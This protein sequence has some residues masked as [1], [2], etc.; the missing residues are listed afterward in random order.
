MNRICVYTVITGNYDTLRDI[1]KTENGIDYICYTNNKKIKSK[2]WNVKYISDDKL[3]DLELSRKI[4]MLGTEELK[5]YDVTIYIDGNFTIT[6][7]VKKFIKDYVDLEKYDLVGFK[8]SARDSINE[9]MLACLIYNKEIAENIFKLYN[10]YKKEK[11]PDNFGLIEAGILF[12]NFNNVTLNKCMKLWF[13]MYLKYSHR[14]Q[15]S[16]QYVAWV[17]GLK[18]NLLNISIWDNEYFESV[19]HVIVDKVDVDIFFKQGNNFLGDKILKK[20]FDVKDS[21]IIGSI[22]TDFDYDEAILKFNCNYDLVLYNDRYS[23]FEIT[24]KNNIITENKIL[25]T[26][27]P[28]VVL[29][30]YNAKIFDVRLNGYFSDKKTVYLDS[31]KRAV[32]KMNKDIQNAEFCYNE[33]ERKFKNTEIELQEK[34]SDLQKQYYELLLKYEKIVNSRRWKITNKLF[35]IKNIFKKK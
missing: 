21:K 32:H 27:N 24:Y 10:F 20:S 9:E 6:K 31:Y 33:K 13:E 8:H 14:D 15:L 29:K 2:F 19:K 26:S 35:N 7:S 11:F 28:V 5:K 4:K 12:R 17:T 18:Y 25:F 22:N 34:N 3:S 23:E 1:K 16:F 30:P